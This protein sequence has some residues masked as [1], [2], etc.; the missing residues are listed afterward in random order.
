LAQEDSIS[1]QGERDR[2]HKNESEIRRKLHFPKSTQEDKPVEEY[3]Q[4]SE[5]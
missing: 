1:G 5:E 3:F 4:N 2:S